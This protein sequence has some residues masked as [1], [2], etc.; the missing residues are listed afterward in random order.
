VTEIDSKFSDF[1]RLLYLRLH[2]ISVES[3]TAQYN[4][5]KGRDFCDMVVMRVPNQAMLNALVH[6]EVINPKINPD[7]FLCRHRDFEGAT[8]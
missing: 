2:S 1:I 6:Q 8:A 3:K 7:N 4:R 5:V